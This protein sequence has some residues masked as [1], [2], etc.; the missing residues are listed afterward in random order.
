MIIF[1]V[2]YVTVNYKCR[3]IQREMIRGDGI[4]AVFIVLFLIMIGKNLTYQ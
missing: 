4:D 1:L 2:L 3:R